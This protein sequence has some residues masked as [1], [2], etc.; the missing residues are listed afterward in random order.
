MSP[1]KETKATTQKAKSI[2]YTHPP[3]STKFNVS[4]PPHS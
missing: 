2:V 1:V 3:P 4:F